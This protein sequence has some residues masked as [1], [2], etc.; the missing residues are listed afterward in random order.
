M[1]GGGG[2]VRVGVN[3][4]NVALWYVR[5]MSYSKARNSQISHHRPHGFS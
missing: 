5:A 2:G 3:L 1:C 4:G